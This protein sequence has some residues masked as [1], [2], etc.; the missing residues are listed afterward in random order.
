M[1]ARLNLG[2]RDAIASSYQFNHQLTAS[3]AGQMMA[4]NGLTAEN[5]AK[6]AT[7]LVG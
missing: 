2:G 4:F 6:R 3:S 7:E 1:I 5:L